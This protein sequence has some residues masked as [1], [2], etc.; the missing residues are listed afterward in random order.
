MYMC[1]VKFSWSQH[2]WCKKICK[3]K[4]N[5]WGTKSNEKQVCN[6]GENYIGNEN[7]RNVNT[8]YNERTDYSS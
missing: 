5:M 8:E 7:E 2:L 6:V 1:V 3:L 4:V